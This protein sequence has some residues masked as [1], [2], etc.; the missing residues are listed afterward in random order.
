VDMLE[1]GAD[2]SLKFMFVHFFISIG[3]LILINIFFRIIVIYIFANL[4][5]SYQPILVDDTLVSF[6]LISDRLDNTFVF[7]NLGIEG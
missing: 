1:I 4:P 3:I 7:R 6:L 5:A 2:F